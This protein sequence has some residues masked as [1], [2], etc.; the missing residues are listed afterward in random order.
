[1][2][3]VRRAGPDDLLMTPSPP[4]DDELPEALHPDDGPGDGSEEAAPDG[5]QG[6]PA[7]APPDP[8]GGAPDE[9]TSGDRRVRASLSVLAVLAAVAVLTIAVVA[10]SSALLSSSD[11]SA[12]RP[13]PRHGHL[14]GNRAQAG[15]HQAANLP[16][17]T[18]APQPTPPSLAGAAPLRSHE[19][20][21]YA[22]YWTLPQ[23][24]QYD[25]KDLT[26]LA[27]F[28]IGVNADGSLDQSGPGWNGYQSQDLVDLVDRAHAA[29]DR[30]VLAVNCFSQRSLDKLTSDPAAP[31]RLSAAL[32]AAVKAKSMDGVNLDFE[33]LGSHDRAGLTALVTQVS[34][35]VHAADP[36]WQV[37]VAT[38][39][40]SATDTAGFYDVA[41][42]A[43]VVDAF[44]VM[45]YD[46]NDK[47][48]PGPT[49]PL[50]GGSTNDAS[51]V[52]GYLKVAPASKIILGLPYYGYDW[53]TTDGKLPA[54][55]TGPE[56]PLSYAAI[57][58]AAH[59]AYWDPTTSTPWTSYKVGDQWHVL[60][61][62][63]PTSL[64]LKAQLADFFHLAG[65]G[66][67]ALGMDG[68][69]PAMLAALLGHAPAAKDAQTGPPP[70][71]G[72]GYLSFA[73]Y[74][75]VA[76]IPLTPIAPPPSGGTSQQVGVLD[77]FGT[78]D[79]ALACL[80][81]GGPLPV[82]TYSTLPGVL[83]VQAA[84]PAQCA[85]AVFTFV[86]PPPSPGGPPTTV[87]PATTTTVPR[88]TTTTTGPVPPTTSTS[89]T[90]TT[91]TTTTAP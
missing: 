40:S 71:P 66:I 90:S 23:A 20:F 6:A 48:V 87:P 17:A 41:A 14:Q 13:A 8:D 21:G 49:S 54:T 33:G 43:P 51:A 31:G 86:A 70:P 67:W 64:A 55:A 61:Y 91:S 26:T 5:D 80:Q 7:D 44:F 72:T 11:T 69:D 29:G 1:M 65:V 88:S 53:P 59:P 56:S 42:L 50:F 2:P 74:T 52:A 84:T 62:D 82:L 30:V 39:A 89:T 45:A 24:A 10:V 83:V 32:I 18:T 78:T 46:M 34:A 75:G 9:G 15:L 57:K 28:S 47:A 38:Y 25:V 19:V 73:T 37:S 85:D 68:N 12:T 76:A 63:D 79:P 77:G 35:A 81:T 58:A 4:T 27:Y 3:P 36:H 60:F 16:A 22:P